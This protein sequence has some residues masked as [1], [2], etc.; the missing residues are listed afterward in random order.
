MSEDLLQVGLTQEKPVRPKKTKQQIQQEN[1]IDTSIPVPP[2]HLGFDRN[3]RCLTCGLKKMT[4]LAG[5]V[6]CP[7]EF[8]E[9]PRNI[10]E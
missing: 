5:Y 10:K 3:G 6:Y 9:C 1:Q 2:S 8:P 7:V 4:N